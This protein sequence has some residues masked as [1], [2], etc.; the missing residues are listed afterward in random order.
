[1]LII[2]LILTMNPAYKK[3][4][5]DLPK[6]KNNLIKTSK[7]ENIPDIVILKSLDK[8]LLDKKHYNDFESL[9]KE[10]TRLSKI[11]NINK[12]NIIS[13]KSVKV[14]KL[15]QLMIFIKSIDIESSNI[16]ID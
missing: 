6:D 16:T 13:D 8:Y 9:K 4:N 14:E 12:I 2:F 3:I 5:I 1:M 7:K 15:V 11:N 10:L